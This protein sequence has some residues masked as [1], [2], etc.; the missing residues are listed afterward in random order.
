MNKYK[1]V[2]CGQKFTGYGNN[3]A[4]LRSSGKCCD[5]CN[6][7]IVIPARI[8]GISEEK[9]SLKVK[10]KCIHVWV[11]ERNH[12]WNMGIYVFCKKCLETKA[13]KY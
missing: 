13:V 11:Q 8:K 6:S 5:D 2:F 3:P 10:K 9:M 4:P 1:C 7:T 12:N